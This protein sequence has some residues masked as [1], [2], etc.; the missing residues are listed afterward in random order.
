MALKQDMDAALDAR[1]KKYPDLQK[2]FRFLRT[3]KQ[4]A[5]RFAISNSVSVSR[6]RYNDHGEVHARIA[7]FSAVKAL[8]I[9][10]KRGVEPTLTHEFRS[11]SF[12]DA[13]EVVL[14]AAYL[15]DIGNAV[16]RDR[17]ELAGFFSAPE[18]L[19]RLYPK[20][21]ELSERKKMLI[22]EGILCHMGNFQPA[23]LEARIIPLAD[24]C[25]ME[26][27]RARIPYE[28]G[29]KDIHSLSALAIKKV[30]L[31][32]GEKKPLRIHVE[33]DSSAGVFQVEENL[34]K[35]IKAAGMEP[36]VEIHTFISSRNETIDYL[37]D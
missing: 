36:Y 26:E 34:L 4:L 15:H 1:L 10:H 14:V 17:H 7:A 5:I 19:A 16:L 24:G 35:K 22:L 33:M 27:G 23:S 13:L 20:S 11:A 8:E 12:T 18:I 6:M 30:R 3:D 9:L 28:H 37:K 31:Y 29:K 21:D 2:T 32:E 25:D